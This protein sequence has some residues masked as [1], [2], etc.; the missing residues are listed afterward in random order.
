LILS[1]IALGTIIF[2]KN[3]KDTPT[4]KILAIGNSITNHGKCDYWWG[5]WGMAA[6]KEQNDYKHRLLKKRGI[7]KVDF[8]FLAD[9]EKFPNK[10]REIL[11]YLDIYLKENYDY[12]IIQL[13][14]N[15]ADSPSLEQDTTELINYVKEKNNNPQ[16][17]IVGNFWKN[18]KFDKIKNKVAQKTHSSYFDL[19][20]I[21]DNEKYY[22]KIGQKVYGEDGKQHKITLGPVANHPNDRAMKYIADKIYKEIK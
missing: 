12:V 16:I 4:T 14:E 10:R 8:V 21:Q 19:K 6:S 1:I 18:D 17:I 7:E 2:I 9:W 15:V 20:E 22:H 3:P 11:S 5:N 13:G